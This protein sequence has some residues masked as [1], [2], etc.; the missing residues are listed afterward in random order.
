[1]NETYLY[2]YS[3]EDARR[4][5]ELAL[6][7]ASHK[8][9]IACKEAIEE[10]VRSHFDGAYLDEDCLDD[11]LREFG[12]KR[13]AWVLANTV[14]QLD[15]D[16]RFIIEIQIGEG[17]YI[18]LPVNLPVFLIVSMNTVIVCQQYI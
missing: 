17:Q 4:Q 11:V 9:N 3:A 5:N 10:A 1:M 7:R 14:Q 18:S 12:Y 6:W 8:A 16:G 13:T 15:W 2:P